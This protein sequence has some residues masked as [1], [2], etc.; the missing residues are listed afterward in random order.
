MILLAPS[1]TSPQSL[2]DTCE[3][4]LYYLDMF[5]NFSK[6]KCIRF[7]HRY[8]NTYANI[9]T[10]DGKI[11][12]WVGTCRYIGLLF[13]WGPKLNKSNDNAKA[14]FYLAFNSIMG[15][16]DRCASNEVTVSLIKAK[17]LAIL[18]YGTEA[19]HF[20]VRETTTLEYP[21]SCALIKVF[22]IKSSEILE[23]CKL[24]FGFRPSTLSIA[25]RKRHF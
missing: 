23:N 2:L 20:S 25:I 3:D 11:I 13:I 5:I 15:K 7:G 22:N 21:I 4:E 17:C 24:A 8:K 6:S 18:L 19:C 1:V 9:I 10:R 16:I 14:K 12:E